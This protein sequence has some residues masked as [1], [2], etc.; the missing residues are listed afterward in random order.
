MNEA[1]TRAFVDA[2]NI[3]N[4]FPTSNTRPDAPNMRYLFPG[5]VTWNVPG[6]PWVNIRVFVEL[7]KG[8]ME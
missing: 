6:A 2:W 5:M 4:G 3:E 1:Q 8:V 7:A